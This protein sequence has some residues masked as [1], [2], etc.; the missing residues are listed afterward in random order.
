MVWSKK[1]STKNTIFKFSTKSDVEKLSHLNF[2]PPQNSIHGI[3]IVFENCS[4]KCSECLFDSNQC[5]YFIM[6]QQLR[7]VAS[8]LSVT[9]NT[10]LQYQSIVKQTTLLAIYLKIVKKYALAIMKETLALAHW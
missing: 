8:A 3:L 5:G 6:I 2:S 9:Q 7:I 1:M 10:Y 4:D